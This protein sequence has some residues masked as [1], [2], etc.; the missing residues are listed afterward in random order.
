MV[1][2]FKVQII[3]ISCND[4]RKDASIIVNNVIIN[5]KFMRLFALFT[6]LVS[7]VSNAFLFLKGIHP[8]KSITN[9][10]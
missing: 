2:R 9:L 8:Q 10:A 1:P 4:S 6:F 3:C 5:N 7:R